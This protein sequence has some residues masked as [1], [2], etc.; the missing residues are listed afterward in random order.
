MVEGEYSEWNDKV[1]LGLKDWF[2]GG[3]FE[4]GSDKESKHEV[5]GQKQVEHYN[6]NIYYCKYY[7]IKSV[8]VTTIIN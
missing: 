1:A 4:N 7:K 5:K 8:L 6:L 3:N 2:V